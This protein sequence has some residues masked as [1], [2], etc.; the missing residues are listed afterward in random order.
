LES[1]CS[2]GEETYCNSF[3]R[4]EFIEQ[5]ENIW[6]KYISTNALENNAKG[7]YS[8]KHFTSHTTKLC[9]VE[10]KESLHSTLS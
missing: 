10:A 5:I 7:M 6:N 2:Y 4:K 9:N 8:N 1:G 3:G